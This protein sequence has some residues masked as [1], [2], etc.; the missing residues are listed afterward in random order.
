MDPGNTTAITFIAQIY[1]SMKDFDKAKEYNERLIKL[2][3]NNQRPLL[4][5]RRAGLGHLLPPRTNSAEG[6][7]H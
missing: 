7:R 2:E 1:Y 6:P 3:P 4:L 5:D